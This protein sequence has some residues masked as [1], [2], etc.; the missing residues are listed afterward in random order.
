MRSRLK[1]KPRKY[2]LQRLKIVRIRF[3]ICLIRFC[4]YYMSYFRNTKDCAGILQS[5]RN[6]L[7]VQK[8][9]CNIDFQDGGHLVFPIRTIKGTFDP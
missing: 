2:K 3:C 7:W 5:S 6:F 1:W 8:K 9:N 4:I